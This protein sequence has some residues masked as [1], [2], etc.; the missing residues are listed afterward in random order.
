VEIYIFQ[1]SYKKTVTLPKII[2]SPP[3]PEMPKFTPQ[4]PF[5]ALF[6]PLFNLFFLPILQFPC[7]RLVSFTFYSFFTPCAYFPPNYISER[8]PSP[9]PRWGGGEEVFSNI[10]IP[11]TEP[12]D[13]TWLSTF[14]KDVKIAAAWTC[15]LASV[16]PN[17]E[18]IFSGEGTRI[19]LV[20]SSCWKRY[21]T[22]SESL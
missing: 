4:I 17:F 19:L 6:L 16:V 12:S 13:F 11:E 15:I 18:S 14:G 7:F 1:I 10:Y 2:S 3:L 20:I 8:L 5:S 21:G 22:Y 9:P